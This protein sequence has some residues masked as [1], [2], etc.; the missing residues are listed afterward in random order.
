M[1]SL[2]SLR[3]RAL[4]G[5]AH[6]RDPAASLGERRTPGRGPQPFE[7]PRGPRRS[8]EPDSKCSPWNR[9]VS[10]HCEELLRRSNP[11][12]HAARLDCFAALAM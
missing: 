11:V 3:E 9:A 7:T 5:G 4:V 10:R 2:S 12:W 6:S 1:R 8:A